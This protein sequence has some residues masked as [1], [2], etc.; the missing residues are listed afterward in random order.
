MLCMNLEPSDK[1]KEYLV[2]VANDEGAEEFRKVFNEEWE[3][4]FGNER[5]PK[6]NRRKTD[7]PLLSP[8]TL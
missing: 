3:R 1:L 7:L 8:E 2:K 4:Q 5:K 6:K